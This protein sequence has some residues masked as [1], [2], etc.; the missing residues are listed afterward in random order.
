ML[1]LPSAAT[2]AASLNQNPAQPAR[3]PRANS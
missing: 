2:G 1:S 3:S